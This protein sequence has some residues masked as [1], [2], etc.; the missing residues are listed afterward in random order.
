MLKAHNK[1]LV[2]M[3]V[4]IVMCTRVYRV[5]FKGLVLMKYKKT[6]VGVIFVVIILFVGILLTQPLLIK[7]IQAKYKSTDHFLV[8]KKDSRIRYEEP[9]KKNV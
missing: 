5:I 4:L 2:R 1:A 9:A 3:H 7:A 8:L 6:I